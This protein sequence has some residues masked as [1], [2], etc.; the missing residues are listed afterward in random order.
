MVTV[1]KDIKLKVMPPKKA[2]K[3]PKQHLIANIFLHF[4]E[5]FGTKN[6]A[7]SCQGCVGVFVCFADRQV[8]GQ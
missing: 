4:P 2:N 5:A 3:Q 6:K 8:T 7:R 1:F